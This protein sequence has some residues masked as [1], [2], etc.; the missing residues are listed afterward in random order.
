LDIDDDA[1]LDA[2]Y[3]AGCD[4][5]TFATDAGGA[6]AV[7]HRQAPTPEQAVLSAI[8]S[9]ESAGGPVRAV[10]V[11]AEDD[12]L[13]T[14]EIAERIGRSR[15]SISQL[16]RGERGPGGFPAPVARCGARSP[17][18]S[19]AE[20]RV[21]FARH[22]PSE[23]PTPTEHMSADFFAAVNDRL[24]LRER[25]RRVPHAPWWA[26]VTKVIPLVS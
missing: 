5:A 21:W 4:D 2:L 20:V 10:R 3:E 8:R 18:F 24:D 11:A 22:L 26:E 19:W 7:F 14:A 1:Y 6:Y 12:W 23:A 16:V 13:T 17:L 9:V 15:Q 25:L